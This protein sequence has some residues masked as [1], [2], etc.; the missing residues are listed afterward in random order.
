MLRDDI[1]DKIS[2]CG[3]R[4]GGRIR[5]LGGHKRSS[6][7]GDR[8]MA[9]AGL[10]ESGD[11]PNLQHSVLHALSVAMSASK[12]T[13]V[14]LP[15]HLSRELARRARATKRGKNWV[16]K[17]ALEQYLL[18]SANDRLRDE[19]RRQSLLVSKHPNPDEAAWLDRVEDIPEWKA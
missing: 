5:R 17:E 2:R 14:R 8:R 11:N 15:P 16:I 19:A 7:A 6:C 10:A 9:R 1:A 18:G 4:R 3:R 13:S 12:T